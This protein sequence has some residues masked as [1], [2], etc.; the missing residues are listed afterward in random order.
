[1]NQQLKT[2]FA[3]GLLVLATFGPGM[4]G[5]FEDGQ[6]AYQRGDYAGA[7]RLLRPLAEEGNAAAQEKLGVMYYNGKGV[8]QDNAQAVVWWRKAAEQGNAEGQIALGLRY[9]MGEGLPQDKAQGLAWFRKA[10]EQGNALGQVWVGV[11]YEAGRSVPQDYV[12]AHMW[13][14]LAASGASDDQAR[15]EAVKA[16]DAI[17]AKM[18]PAQIAEAQRLASEWK[19]KK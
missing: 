18:T 14:N 2:F 12:R 4:A 19:P 6:A 5:P 15:E 7:M 17:A 8:P 1:M 10:A 11:A 9:I 13:Y 16:R 3:S